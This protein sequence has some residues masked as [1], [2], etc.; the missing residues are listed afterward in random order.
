MDSSSLILYNY[1]KESKPKTVSYLIN[2]NTTILNDAS[3]EWLN[4]ILARKIND[5]QDK[6]ISYNL[7]ELKLKTMSYLINSKTTIQNDAS[8]EWLDTTL[9][10]KINDIQ[11][12]FISYNELIASST[13]VST[14]RAEDENT[15]AYNDSGQIDEVPQFEFYESLLLASADLS[16]IFPG[17]HTQFQDIYSEV[18][19]LFGTAKAVRWLNS[20]VLKYGRRKAF[21]CNV[22]FTISH[23]E[24]EDVFPEG[25]IIAAAFLLNVDD[26]VSENALTAFQNWNNRESLEILNATKPKASWLFKNWQEAIK[27]IEENGY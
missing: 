9:T 1:L 27:Y 8:N 16:D 4:I 15:V 18:C 20:L 11:D 22:L 6:F 2:S 13:R 17:N 7:K 24:Y 14:S 25:Q 23:M 5:I 12:K 3:N 21:I 19:T 26:Q 10:R